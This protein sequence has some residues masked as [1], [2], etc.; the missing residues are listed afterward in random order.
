MA[1]DM[2]DPHVVSLHYRLR[3]S[4][5]LD[6]GRAE[7]LSWEEEHFC[8]ILQ[9]DELAIEMKT[10]ARSEKEAR[11]LVEPLLRAWEVYAGLTVGVDVLTFRFA[12]ANIIDRRPPVG[13]TASEC[14]G[15]V[16]AVR[17]V[18]AVRGDSDELYRP[19]S[20]PS[21]PKG[22][23]ASCDVQNMYERYVAYRQGREP[24]PSMGN[25]VLTMLERTT[26]G[27]SR[28]AKHYS[29]AQPVLDTLGELC[30]TR[31]SPDEARKAPK[32]SEAYHPL[33]C[34]E[35]EWLVKAIRRIIM[36]AGERAAK[37]AGRLDQIAM[38]DLP[39]L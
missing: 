37:P 38:G 32:R 31:G 27:R 19:A 28:A 12:G 34:S 29:L 13:V 2:K 1:G 18:R 16:I 33:T 20:Y 26:G 7:P 4:S 30:A 14:V 25:A 17:A 3:H 24:L 36:R 35:R 15:D 21:P 10:H 5:C 23:V 9:S 8:A 11:S 22:F 39:P 6:Y